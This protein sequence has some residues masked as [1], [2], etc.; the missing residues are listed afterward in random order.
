MGFVCFEFIHLQFN[1]YMESSDRNQLLNTIS[2]F[3]LIS[4]VQWI[5]HKDI[6]SPYFSSEKH[7]GWRRNNR[8]PWVKKYFSE[9][10]DEFQSINRS[11][12]GILL[13]IPDGLRLELFD[14]LNLFDSD[15]DTK[16]KIQGKVTRINGDF[17]FLSISENL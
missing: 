6:R 16:I 11:P 5:L 13:R 15:K 4:F 2:K 1:Y 3:V 9:S 10:G 14:E 12:N 8:I 17:A 7:R